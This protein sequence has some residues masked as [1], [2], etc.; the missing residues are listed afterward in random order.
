MVSVSACWCAGVVNV[1]WCAGDGSY[2]EEGL[3]RA[4]VAH[5][6]SQ[7][8]VCFVVFLPFCSSNIMFMSHL[9]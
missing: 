1:C 8:C 9:A 7:V 5:R 3:E 6:F 2:I 4:S